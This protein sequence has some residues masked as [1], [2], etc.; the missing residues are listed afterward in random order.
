MSTKPKNSNG[1]GGAPKGEGSFW[2]TANWLGPAY[3]FCI[4]VITGAII[5]AFHRWPLKDA[6]AAAVA[7]LVACGIFLLGLL[8]AAAHRRRGSTSAQSKSATEDLKDTPY[9]L[10][11]LYV[12]LLAGAVAIFFYAIHFG[13]LTDFVSAFSVGLLGACGALLAGALLGLL[14]GMP[15]DKSSG[16]SSKDSD[17]NT[18]DEDKSKDGKKN[19]GKGEASE[20][21]PTASSPFRPSTR[22]QEIADWLTKI[23]IGLGLAEISKIPSKLWQ[24]AHFLGQALGNSPTGDA[25]ALTILVAYVTA[26]F[27]IGFIWSDLYLPGVL[28][29]TYYNLTGRLKKLE[30]YVAKYDLNALRLSEQWLSR[31]PGDGSAEEK[32]EG[33]I[34]N[35]IKNA[36]PTARY[37]TFYQAYEHDRPD[38]TRAQRMA[39]RVAI[40]Q[41]LVDQDADEVFHRNRGQLGIALATRTD[42]PKTPPA[43][44][45]DQAIKHLNDAIRIRDQNADTGWRNYEFYLAYSLIRHPERRN[46]ADLIRSYLRKARQDN[47]LLEMRLREAKDKKAN[48]VR[49]IVPLLRVPEGAEKAATPPNAP[50]KDP[51]DEYTVEDFVV[52]SL[53]FESNRLSPKQSKTQGAGAVDDWD[54]LDSS[55]KGDNAPVADRPNI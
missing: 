45:L 50:Y 52:I 35:A 16:G 13:S 8:V 44:D 20:D 12:I 5:F 34:S 39:R 10:A 55:K 25:V 33:E 15:V 18:G 43:D 3:G 48:E 6:G 17:A 46:E 40:Y 7:F 49:Q 1:T 38:W 23:I 29:Q 27:L 9:W 4:A 2:N 28:A 32:F 41:A 22:L 31:Y 21:G 53:W 42:L 47:K 11:R 51:Y 26:G 37:Q 14:Y 36:S 30:N 54:L 24:L 19:N